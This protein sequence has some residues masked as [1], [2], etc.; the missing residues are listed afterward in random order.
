MASEFDRELN[1]MIDPSVPE[2]SKIETLRHSAAHVMADA[3]V[4]IW[5]DAKLAFGPHT[6][7]GFYYDIDM[8]HRLAPDDLES[9]EAKMS[10]IVKG[11]HPFERQEIGRAEAIEMFEARG[12]TYKVEA[13]NSIPGDAPLTLYRSC[14]LYTS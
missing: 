1:H 12:E 9:I 3:I 6:E 2:L 14:L 5:P 11:R 8:S 7:D 13:I 4:A 10:E